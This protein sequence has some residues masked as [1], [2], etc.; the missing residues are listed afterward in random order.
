MKIGIIGDTHFGAAYNIGKT[1]GETQLNSRLIDFSNTFN[2]IVD[3]FVSRDVKVL[4]LTGDI[5]ET[6]HPTSAQLNSFSRCIQRATELGMRVL[7]VVGNH[8]QQRNIDTTTVDIFNYLNIPNVSVFPDIDSVSLKDEHGKDF[9]LVLM[10]YRDRRMVN[11]PSNSEAIVVLKNILSKLIENKVGPKILVGHLMLEKTAEAENPDSFS[12][13]ELVLPFNTFQG[14]DAV[15]MG[16]V[17]KHEVMSTKN[18]VIIYTGSMEKVSFGEKDHNKVT[19]VLDTDD[20]E[21]FEIIPTNTR[22]IFE[23]NFDYSGGDKLFKDEISNKINSDIDAFD[24]KTSIKDAIVKLV[25]RVK[26]S[27]LYHVNHQK[28]RDYI[29]S[30]NVNNLVPMQITSIVFRQ[31]RNSNITEDT[32]SKK[33]MTTFIN[34]L[35]EPDNIKRR[36][37]KYADQIID[38]SKG[39]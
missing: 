1:D 14:F 21:N 18:P 17:H 20:I 2:T 5:F 37:Q 34:S 6:R 24:K 7:I 38:D 28:I 25:V 9:H 12:I 32:D 31:L 15:L 35:S 13:N 23:M 10:P 11:T 3:S 8:D 19:V 27:D 16:H 26:D 33:A 22:N 29:L 36:L 30:K 39:K 4:V